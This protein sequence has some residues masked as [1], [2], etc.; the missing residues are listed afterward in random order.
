M[1]SVGDYSAGFKAVPNTIQ[2][3]FDKASETG[4]KSI[5]RVPALSTIMGTRNTFQI[6]LEVRNLTSW[7]AETPPGTS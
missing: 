2:D 3:C 6:T 7:F 5:L 1:E 4:R